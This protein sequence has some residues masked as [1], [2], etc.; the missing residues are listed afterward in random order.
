MSNLDM[1]A[2]EW[3]AR[4]FW[5]ENCPECEKDEKG[6]T[7]TPFMGNWFARCDSTYWNPI[8]DHVKAGMV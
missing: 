5:D 4:F 7:A 2:A 3:L 1:P 8:F 6:H